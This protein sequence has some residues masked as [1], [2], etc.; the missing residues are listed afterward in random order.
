MFVAP[1]PSK[2][3]GLGTKQLD[4]TGAPLQLNATGW[5]KPLFEAKERM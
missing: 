1:E 4:R 5:L 3:T 2:V